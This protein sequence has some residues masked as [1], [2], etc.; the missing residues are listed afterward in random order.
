MSDTDQSAQP[1][2]RADLNPEPIPSGPTPTAADA[3]VAVGGFDFNHPTIIS[4]LYLSAALLGITG[5]VGV[6]LAYVW[7]GEAHAEWETSHYEYLIRTFWIALVGTVVSM[8]L[9][10]VLVGFVLLMAVG[11]LVLVRCVMS[12]VN[13]QKRQP[14]PNPGTLFV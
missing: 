14:M 4:L 11:V 1:A 9:M 6:V 13:A 2:P 5:L 12:L 3:P 7:R 10:L 8:L